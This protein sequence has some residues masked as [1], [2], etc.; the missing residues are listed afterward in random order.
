MSEPAL[1]DPKQL[2]ADAET[3]EAM[4]A[5]AE[6]GQGSSGIYWRAAAALRTVAQASGEIIA[7]EVL[8]CVGVG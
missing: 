3:F 4:A 6:A 7:E 5:A 2:F 8:S 1:F